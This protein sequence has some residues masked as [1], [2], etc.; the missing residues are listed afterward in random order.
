VEFVSNV[1]RVNH[2]R[3]IQCNIRDITERKQAE[4]QVNYHARLLRHIN[5]AVIATDDQIRITA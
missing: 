4:E 2:H 1:Y 3:V 5:D